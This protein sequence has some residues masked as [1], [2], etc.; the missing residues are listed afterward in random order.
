MS[1]AY[2]SVNFTLLKQALHQLALPTSIISILTDLLVD[3]QNQVITNLGLTLPY[4]VQ[5][6]IDQGETITPLLWQ[7]YYDPLI[8]YIYTNSS[9]YTTE[10]SWITNLKSHTREKAKTHYSV[11]AYMDDTLWIAS[12]CNELANIISI[13]ESFYTWQISRSIHPNQFYQLIANQTII[14]LLLLITKL[15]LFGHLNNPSNF[16]DAGSHLTISKLNKRN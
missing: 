14:L 5:N 7:I 15:C 6:G 16:L 4:Q 12:S 8:T 3:R 2:D 1:K 13:A 9:G 11:L 10:T